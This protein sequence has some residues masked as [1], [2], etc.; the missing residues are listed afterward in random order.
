MYAISEH[1]LNIPLMLVNALMYL[2][3]NSTQQIIPNE[4]RNSDNLYLIHRVQGPTY[5]AKQKEKQYF[6]GSQA[7]WV[8]YKGIK[9]EIEQNKDFSQEGG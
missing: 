8:L 7:T 5:T 4:G 1:F 3:P 6:K 9:I 2:A